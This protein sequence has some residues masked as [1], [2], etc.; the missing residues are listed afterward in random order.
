MPTA[1]RCP[2]HEAMHAACTARPQPHLQWMRSPSSS[3]SGRL[4]Q[5]GPGS[6]LVLST[7][8][9]ERSTVR[10]GTM[11][12]R[13]YTNE[14]EPTHACGAGSSRGGGGGNDASASASASA[15]ASAAAFWVAP[16]SAP[17]PAA[18]PSPFAPAPSTLFA[19][20][21]PSSSP[22][23]D[24]GDLYRILRRTIELL[25]GV[26]AVPYVS[27]GVQRRASA[28]LR[29]MNRFPVADDTLMGVPSMTAAAPDE[30]VVAAPDEAEAA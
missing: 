6:I 3:G 5:R 29:A 19:L 9:L 14:S 2:R 1:L 27:P 22:S 30:A 8:P 21:P 12:R 23:L 11:C 25:R 10:G 28:A 24:G 17:A 20:S 16:S 15:F 7:T 4:T 26:S 18:S 13:S